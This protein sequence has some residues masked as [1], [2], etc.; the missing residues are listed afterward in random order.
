[1]SL[2]FSLPLAHGIGGVKDLPVPAWLFYYGGAI[3]L[4]LS[5]VAL[6][7]LWR[8]PR[9]EHVGARR[10]LTIPRAVEL[11]CGALGVAAFVVLI[12]AGL[13]GRA[14]PRPSVVR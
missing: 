9:L 2:A 12:Y 1:M 10:V 14:P 11:I 7:A 6:G 8:S 3:V 13:A 4:V 5:F